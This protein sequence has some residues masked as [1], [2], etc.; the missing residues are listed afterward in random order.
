VVGEHFISTFPVTNAAW[1]IFEKET[2]YK[3]KADMGT[4]FDQPDL[5]VVGVSYNDAEAFCKWAGLR[6]PKEMEWEY[7]ARGS[8]ERHYP[9]GNKYPSQSFCN[10][11]KNI[12]DEKSPATTPQGTFTEGISAMGCEDMAGNVAEWC[13]PNFEDRSGRKPTRGGHWLS[14]VYAINCYYH[15]MQQPD[16]RNNRTGFRVVA[17]KL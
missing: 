6:L 3:G 13:I 9:W 1:S 2:D 5:P 8:D 4:R 12:F 11:G 15:D 10:Y 7:A 16:T 17:E 14:A